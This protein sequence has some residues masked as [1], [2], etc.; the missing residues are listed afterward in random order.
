MFAGFLPVLRSGKERGDGVRPGSQAWDLL[1][2]SH[3]W[4]YV[5]ELLAS[6]MTLPF[7][8]QDPEW[9]LDGGLPAA[10]SIGAYL[11]QELVHL[12]LPSQ[13]RLL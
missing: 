9:V 12:L 10:P 11:V 3:W 2:L 5:P 4:G 7:S 13:L 1:L 6:S 8:L